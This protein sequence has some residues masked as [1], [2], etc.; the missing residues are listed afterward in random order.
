MKHD[1]LVENDKVCI[2]IVSIFDSELFKIDCLLLFPVKMGTNKRMRYAKNRRF[3]SIR[4]A[5]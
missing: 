5:P 3:F 4:A 2:Q 1:Q